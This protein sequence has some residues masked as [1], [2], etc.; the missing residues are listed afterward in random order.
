M[1]D[2]TSEKLTAL[3]HLDGA[4]RDPVYLLAYR[5]LRECILAGT[6]PQGKLLP[7]EKILAEAMGVGRTSLRTALV[8]L[9]EDGYVETRHGKGTYVTARL[10]DA[11]A[12]AS[13]RCETMR[14]KL[15]RLDGILSVERAQMIPIEGDAFL[16][17]QLRAG[18]GP[19][20]AIRAAY[21]LDG[22]LAAESQLFVK[23]GVA[24]TLEEAELLFTARVEYTTE[25][26]TVTNIIGT[27]FDHSPLWG[28]KSVLLLSG[29]WYTKDHEPVCYEK[30]YID[31]DMYRPVIRQ[32]RQTI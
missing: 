27:E 18:G 21:F 14:E 13:A 3:L 4:G 8:L 6:F 31:T 23:K 2:F 32:N 1:E 25:S 9:A 29:G 26:F 28:Q 20:T 10:P 22:R 5:R 19:L 17:E 24:N 12:Q 16:D 15:L 30:T 11:D 7:T